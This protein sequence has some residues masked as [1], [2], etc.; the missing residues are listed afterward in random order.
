[1]QLSNLT[2]QRYKA[3]T[4]QLK[5]RFQHNDMAYHS[6][7]DRQE[8]LYSEDGEEF[9]CDNVFARNVLGQAFVDWINEQLE[10]SIKFESMYFPK[11]YNFEDDQ[12]NV[13]FTHEDLTKVLSW[14]Q[15]S[16]NTEV[17]ENLIDEY[18]TTRSG[19]IAFHSKESFNSSPE[20]DRKSVV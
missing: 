18:S 1:M 4:E 5:A 10:T 20:L 8:T 11:E 7:Y 12:I 2:T 17:L 14:V 6:W 3:M 19:Y 13:I 9:D 15:C 16:Q